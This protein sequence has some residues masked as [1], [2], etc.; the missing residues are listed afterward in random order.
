MPDRG[1][2]F[3]SPVAETKGGAQFRGGGVPDKKT[4]KKYFTY[5]D[6]VVI[7]EVV[8][9]GVRPINTIGNLEERGDD[10]RVAHQEGLLRRQPV[11]LGTNG[12][13][14]KE[15]AALYQRAQRK[16]VTYLNQNQDGYWSLGQTV[17]RL[18][19][20][21][22]D[23]VRKDVFATQ[24]VETLPAPAGD[25]PTREILEF[26]EQYSR[27]LSRFQSEYYNLYATVQNQPNQELALTNAVEELELALDELHAVM[28]VQGLRPRSISMDT[29]WKVSRD[30]AGAFLAAQGAGI[31]TEF[32]LGLAGGAAT[33]SLE[34]ASRCQPTSWPDEIKDY[35][36]LFRVDQELGD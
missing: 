11:D 20:P 1:L 29:L 14:S 12:F 21:E 7:A 5:W 4:L 9:D 16:A 15:I 30:A 34:V 22:E 6:E 10:I 13:H 26:R 33:M 31:S 35:A 32:S 28:E 18:Q 36:Y 27:Q 17:E 25:V 24:L 2:V 8:S 23:T 3:T 19:L